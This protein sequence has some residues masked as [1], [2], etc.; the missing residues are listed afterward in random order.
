MKKML[1]LSLLLLSSLTLSA[2]R[3]SEPTENTVYVTTY[4]VYFLVSNIG[5]DVVNVKY[6]PGS[7]QHAESIDW[8][9]QEIIDM[10][11]ADYLFHVGANLD[12]YIDINYDS[13]F[14]NQNVE[15]VRLEDYIDIINVRL[16][17]DHDHD[18]HDHHD[19][20]DHDNHNHHDDHDDHDNHND[21]DD[22]DD[23]D[24]HNDHDDHDDHDHGEIQPDPHFWLDP[25]RMLQAAHVILEKLVVMYPEHEDRI[26]NNF[27]PL[28]KSLEKL[29]EDFSQ[30][31]ESPNRPIITNVKLFSYFEDAYNITIHPFTLNAHAHEDESVPTNFEEFIQLA[32][33]Y[34]IRFVVFEKNATSPAGETLLSE[35]RK[36][37]SDTDRLALH[38][39]ESLTREEIAVNKNYINIMYDNLE[40]LIK[41]IE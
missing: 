29:H 12:P 18:D 40:A 23:H 6:V 26:N 10:Q 20:N 36:S 3:D 30:A 24:N 1:F 8:A 9:A 7:Q 31:L 33:D 13:T 22:H 21:H 19:H 17:H 16:I 28:E 5:Q 11:D 41:A 35:L 38:P 34:N 37:N 2:C 4:P 15:L 32:N 27:V 25:Q 39:L 14:R